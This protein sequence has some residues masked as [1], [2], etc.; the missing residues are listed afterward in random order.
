MT[1]ED[2][3]DEGR[4][5]RIEPRIDWTRAIAA[6]RTHHEDHSP[7]RREWW[8]WRWGAAIVLV[9]AALLTLFRG[10]LTDMLWPETRVQALLDQALMH[11]KRAAN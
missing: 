3:P 8:H 4:D 9:L 1:R 10:P 5:R 11:L 2:R 7:V 6:A